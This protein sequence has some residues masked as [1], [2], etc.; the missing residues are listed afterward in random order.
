[1]KLFF[2]SKT[3]ASRPSMFTSL[4]EIQACIEESEEKRLDLEN[5]EGW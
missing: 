2:S 5:T 3:L 4:V 1:M